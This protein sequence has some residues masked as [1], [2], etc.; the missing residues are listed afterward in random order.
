MP[1]P[2]DWIPLD[3]TSSLPLYRQLANGFVTLIQDGRLPAGSRIPGS[4]QLALALGVHRKTV[5]SAYDELLLQGWLTSSPRRYLAVS[6]TPPGQAPEAAGTGHIPEMP[7]FQWAEDYPRL[8]A[9]YP[10]R[11]L[12]FDDGFPDV[13]LAPMEE[14]MRA[15]RKIARRNLTQPFLKYTSPYGIDALREDIAAFVTETRHLPCRP[16][17]ILLTRGAQMAFSLICQSVLRPGDRVAVG[18]LDY[19]FLVQI[20][21]SYGAEI[22]R[23]P[24]TRQG[25]CVDSLEEY[26][27]HEQIR[28]LYLTPHHHYPTTVTLPPEHRE[29]LLAL[30]R[31][32]AFAIVEDDY[33]FDFQFDN[34]PYVPLAGLD[35]SGTTL[36]VG[37][38]SKL[39]APSIR[40]GFVVAPARFVDGLAARRRLIDFQGDSVVEKAL[41]ELFREGVITAHIKKAN[42]IY[43]ERRD[44]LS[45]L[46]RDQLPDETEFELPSGGL[47]LWTRF[48][49]P[50]P[51]IAAEAYRRGLV[52]SDGTFYGP[53]AGGAT[54]LGFASLTLAE[55]EQA[56]SI[57]KESIQAVQ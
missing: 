48:R 36:Y 43:R 22:V 1:F 49:S 28:M 54:R 4:R 16:E 45:A 52:F 2:S 41:S 38:F 32:Y 50:L 37:T 19:F 6:A 55:Q 9:G 35:R 5:L 34:R 15:Y 51:A 27:R 46:L 23:I 24:V 14:L 10:G 31:E 12:V 7:A 25:I 13:R 20:A 30:A 47:V 53:N 26:C 8:P 42:R 33:D 17:N 18:E 3:R 11:G 56:V 21:R 29:R 57:L 39:I 44:H 40:V